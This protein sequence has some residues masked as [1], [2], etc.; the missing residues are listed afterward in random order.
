MLWPHTEATEIAISLITCN[1]QVS[2]ATGTALLLNL[3]DIVDV[4]P[5]CNRNVLHDLASWPP[6]AA[7]THNV[8]KLGLV[9][10]ITMCVESCLLSNRK[11]VG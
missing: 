11:I 8:I 10:C 2:R 4:T 1:L 6:L 9:L 7:A 5:Y 3:K